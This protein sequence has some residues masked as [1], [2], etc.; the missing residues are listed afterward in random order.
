[1]L[2]QHRLQDRQRLVRL[3]MGASRGR[4]VFEPTETLTEVGFEPAADRVFMAPDG[5]GNDGNTLT[6]I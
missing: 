3:A 6:T 5:L 4:G 2:G 1:M